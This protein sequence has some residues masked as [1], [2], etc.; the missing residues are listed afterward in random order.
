M[1]LPLNR[2]RVR[3]QNLGLMLNLIPVLIW[4]LVLCQ[5]RKVKILLKIHLCMFTRKIKKQSDRPSH[6]KNSRSREDTVG[7]QL[8]Q[9]LINEQILSQLD[10]IGKCLTAI[11]KCLASA[12]QPKAKKCSS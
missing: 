10:A 12:A 1:N 9:T 5:H 6:F 11:Q 4:K 8:D 3:V 2:N 7:S